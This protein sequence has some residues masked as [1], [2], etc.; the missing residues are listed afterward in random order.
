MSVT[1]NETV[2]WNVPNWC[3][4]KR[5]SNELNLTI[6]S[7]LFNIQL[8]HKYSP[9]HIS[10]KSWFVSLISIIETNQQILKPIP[11]KT[12]VNHSRMYNSINIWDYLIIMDINQ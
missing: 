3:Q 4:W 5:E 8:T 1:F 12:V 7:H 11:G 9:P 2:V 10:K 6:L